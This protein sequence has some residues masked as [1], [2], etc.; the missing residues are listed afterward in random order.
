[1]FRMLKDRLEGIVQKYRLLLDK[2][3]IQFVKSQDVR[4]IYDEMLKNEISLD[5]KINLPDGSIFR[6]RTVH[7]YKENE[8]AIHEDINPETK[9]I[10]Y[11]DQILTILNNEEIDVLIRVGIFH[12]ML[13]YIHP[14]YEGVVLIDLFLHII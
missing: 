6:K 13:G 7:V 11:M 1:M 12:Y 9:I 5:D 8:K 4:N 3:D 2:K 10:Q 14:F